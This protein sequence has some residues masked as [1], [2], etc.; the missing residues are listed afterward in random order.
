MEVKR[1]VL[2]KP[3]KTNQKILKTL[4]KLAL[5]L[6]PLPLQ[7]KTI[8]FQTTIYFF[9]FLLCKINLPILVKRFPQT[10]VSKLCQQ[11]K[12]AF[13]K[14]VFENAIETEAMTKSKEV[15]DYQSLRFS[16]QAV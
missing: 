3:S 7:I 14:G 13:I 15:F 8:N 10:C 16:W 12:Q 11:T 5:T 2:G 1:T 4:S 9:T 6:P